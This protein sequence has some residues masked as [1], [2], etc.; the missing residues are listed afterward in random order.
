MHV[1]D[2][3][4]SSAIYV[5]PGAVIGGFWQ[6]KVGPRTV[7]MVGVAL[8]G[9]GNVLAGLGTSKPAQTVPAATAVAPRRH[10]LP[11]PECCVQHART[12]EL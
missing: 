9:C 11:G 12:V 3:P 4:I 6:D 1:I 5:F 10:R 7:A 8:W 2:W